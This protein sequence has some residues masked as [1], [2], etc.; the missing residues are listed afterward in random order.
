MRPSVADFFCGAG[1]FSEGFRQAGF[2]VAFALDN[3]KP[4]I[5]THEFNHPGC[6]HFLG[7]ILAVPYNKIDELVPDTDV[8]VG[9]PPCVAFSHSNKAGKGDKSLGMALIHKYLQI[10]AIKKNKKG[11][12]LR[13]WVLENVPNS[14]KHIKDSYTFEELG[15]PG[16][17][18]VALTIVTRGIYN[19]AD[20]GAPQTRKRFLCGDFIEPKKT[21]EGEWIHMRD[22]LATLGS[23][24]SDSEGKVKDPVFGFTIPKR[25]LTDHLYDTTIEEFEWKQARR[26]KEDHGYMGR[27]SFPENLDRPS[28]TIMATQ[29]AV[30]RESVIFASGKKGRYRLPTIREIASFM[31]FPIT[32]QFIG[33]SESV[34]YKLVGNAV[35]VKLS[36]SVADA[37]LGSMKMKHVDEPNPH[38]DLDSM[39]DRV[40]FKL[41]G[42]EYKKRE[43][44]KRRSVA[45]FKMHVPHIKVKG[46]RVELDNQDSDFAKG[47]VV[48]K[49]RLHYGAG[50][51]AKAFIIDSKR[52]A[53]G[54]NGDGQFKRYRAELSSEMSKI[55]DDPKKLQEIY[56]RLNDS[57]PG[58]EEFLHDVRELIDRNYPE[59]TFVENRKG[60]LPVPR[61][62]IPQRV[63][64]ALYACQLLSERFKR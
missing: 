28:R 56:C 35:C 60:M 48:W 45:R 36:E 5:A 40:P 18:R 61:D 4:A 6:K 39:L 43:P 27:M 38:K 13:Y 41:D 34:K 10:V 58:P 47:K 33:N 17:D 9:S 3:W 42:R 49:A 62:I 14:A 16:G 1:G 21:N 37:M 32:Y 55:T 44:S 29:S 53:K 50:M 54:F 8:I 31:S 12:R 7:D 51:G 11:S 63:L 52:I 64:A 24:T 57:G 22:V 30:S 46:F 2:E 19:A 25:Y 26:L 23:P 15:L 20:Y 59:E